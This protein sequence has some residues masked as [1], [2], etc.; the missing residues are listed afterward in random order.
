M[1]RMFGSSNNKYGEKGCASLIQLN[2]SGWNTNKVRAI[3][4]IFRGC[5]SLTTLDLSGWNLTNLTKKSGMLL[6]CNAL[7]IIYMVGCDE[8]TINI[9]KQN[10]IDAGLSTDIIK[11]SRE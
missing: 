11:T 9:V 2:L 5:S 4:G 7:K 3:S 1:S 8:T 6:G 10:I